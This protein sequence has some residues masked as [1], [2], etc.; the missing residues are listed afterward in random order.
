M[1]AKER[2]RLLD[3]YMNTGSTFDLMV[4]EV[5]RAVRKATREM[6]ESVVRCQTCGDSFGVKLGIKQEKKGATGR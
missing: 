5:D 3:K 6:N 4:R 2:E 1:M